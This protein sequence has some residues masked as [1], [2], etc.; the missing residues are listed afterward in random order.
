MKFLTPVEAMAQQRAS[1]DYARMTLPDPSPASPF[2]CCDFFDNCSDEILSLYYKGNLTLLDWMGFNVTPDCLRS[3]DFLTYVRPEQYA[4]VDL[5]GYLADPCATPNGVEFGACSLSV[6]DFG[7]YGRS[8]PVR[9]LFKPERFC[10]TRPRK[11]LDGSP[12]TSEWEWDLIFVMDQILNDLRS[13][14]IIGNHA[15]PGQFD[16]LQQWIRS[17]YACEPL[18]STIVDWNANPMAGGAGITINGVPIGGAFNLVDVLLDIHL[19]V[20]DRISWSPLLRNQTRRVGDTILV[21]PSFVARCLLDFYTCWSVCPTVIDTTADASRIVK[22]VGDRR[23]YRIELNGGLFGHG[24][25][26]LDGDEI[27]LLMYDWETIVGPNRG[28]IYYLTGAVG[29]QRIWEGEHLD[30]NVVLREMDV[31]EGNPGGFFVRDGGRYVGKVDTDEL[32]RQMKVW[33]RPRLWCYAP[34]AQARIENVACHRPLGPLSPD[35]GSSF[36]PVTSFDPALCP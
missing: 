11:F 12:V 26:F 10:K 21:L 22:E 7:R 8:G 36:F 5:A 32:C 20:K 34:W 14:L 4:G 2:G 29:A 3:V 30:G 17:N 33:I 24:R 25:I 13:H 27:P 6:E 23:D 9:D 31:V 1:Q 15:T 18:N 19:R 16:G 28:D 35:P